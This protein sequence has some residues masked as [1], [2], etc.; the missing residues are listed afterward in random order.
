MK[1]IEIE[2]RNVLNLNLQK[3]IV[4]VLD[5]AER[6]KSLDHFKIEISNHKGVIQLDY[7]FRERLKA[8]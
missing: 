7:Q 8:Y 5:Q 4:D 6:E 1:E 3:L 2:K